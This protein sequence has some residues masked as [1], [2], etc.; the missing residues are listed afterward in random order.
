MSKKPKFKK[1]QVVRINTEWYRT[2][3]IGQQYQQ[4]VDIRP[5]SNASV[6]TPS[7]MYTFANGYKCNEKYVKALSKTEL[8][9]NKY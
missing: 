4:I 2:A 9:G 5:W 1:K 8:Y 7:F 3:R 6:G